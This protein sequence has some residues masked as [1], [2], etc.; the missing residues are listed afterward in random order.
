MSS[1]DPT[2]AKPSDVCCLKGT[3]HEGEPRGRR[4]TI[5]DVDTYIATPAEGKANGH[6]LLY[7]PDVWGFFNNGF[8][9]MD[10][11]ADRGF[12]TLGLDY[13]RG[14]STHDWLWASVAGLT[15]PRIL[16]GSTERIDLTLPVNLASTMR[17]GKRSTRPLLLNTYRS[18]PRL[19]KRNMAARPLNL[20]A[21]GMSLQA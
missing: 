1:Q 6:I 3:V 12:L 16:S 11:F 18:G 9:V 20:R 8:L 7:F 17:R 5:A 2:I 21:P 14:V 4:E 10:G 13:F 15:S 19:S